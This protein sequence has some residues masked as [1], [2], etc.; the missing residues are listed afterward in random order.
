MK[1]TELTRR[2]M[3]AAWVY[4]DSARLVIEVN[5]E[6]ISAIIVADDPDNWKEAGK[7]HPGQPLS[8]VMFPETMDQ[9]FSTLT[10]ALF[11]L[12]QRLEKAAD[13]SLDALNKELE[14]FEGD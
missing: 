2:I 3:S 10:K 7:P 8:T 4:E 13:D 6:G 14:P 1:V 5:N 12:Y 9:H 11:N